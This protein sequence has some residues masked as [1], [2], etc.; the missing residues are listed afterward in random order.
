MGIKYVQPTLV[1]GDYSMSKMMPIF[2]IIFGLTIVNV[3]IAYAENSG[4]DYARIL[5][6]DQPLDQLETKYIEA[7]RLYRKGNYTD[8]AELFKDVRKVHN[9]YKATNY[10]L[11]RIYRHKRYAK[12]EKLKEEA[13]ALLRTDSPARSKLR[14]E[15]ME[16]RLR[17]E[18]QRAQEEGIRRR[19]KIAKGTQTS[20]N[21]LKKV[22][23]EN[24]RQQMKPYLSQEETAF[25]FKTKEMIKTEKDS[26]RKERKDQKVLMKRTKELYRQA[27]S[28]VKANRLAF[29]QEK[30]SDLE[31]VLASGKLPE[32][33]QKKMDKSY[34]G[35][36]RRLKSSR[37]RQRVDLDF[38]MAKREDGRKVEAD[39]VIRLKEDAQI[40]N[41]NLVSSELEEVVISV[42]AEELLGDLQSGI[43][44]L[45]VNS[46]T[47]Y[48]DRS[49]VQAKMMLKEIEEIW[50]DYKDT[51]SLL[52]VIKKDDNSKQDSL[53]V[54][55]NQD[56]RMNIVNEAL[57]RVMEN[58]AW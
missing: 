12:E 27:S 51:R 8:A 42:K 30:I 18:Q 45:Y 4:G 39:E 10:F 31:Y 41:G 50:P 29:A 2:F 1:F 49:Y 33:F 26:V 11:K 6:R 25:K 36:E 48:N 54:E 16:E 47:Y 44:N 7:V 57:D 34:I 53:K 56:S 17:E 55:N 46:M 21:Y 20:Q 40:D 52:E 58:E 23:K 3:N 5:R 24:V 32:N 43:E 19:S 15:K 14:D 13:K 35:L 28:A 22:Q 37:E 9:P 38:N